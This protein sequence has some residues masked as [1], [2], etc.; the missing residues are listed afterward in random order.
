MPCPD[1]AY[2]VLMVTLAPDARID[3]HTHSWCS[4]GTE[5]PGVVVAQAAK[6]GLDVIGL[7]DHD[8]V[9]GWAQ[10]DAAGQEQGV[11]VVPGIE[12]SCNWRGISVHLLAYLPDPQDEALLAELSASRVSRDTRLQRMVELLAAD[13]FPITYD[14]VL[15]MAAAEASLGRPH[16][17]DVLVRHG[18]FPSRDE[19]FADVLSSHSRYYV[20]HHAPDPVHATEMIVAAGGVPVIAHPFASKRGE[21]VSDDLVADMAD[22]GMVGVEVDHRDHG[23][24]ERAHA[25]ALADRLRLVQ[26]GSSDYHGAGKPNRL[27][28]NTT[29]IASLEAILERATGTGLLGAQ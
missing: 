28:E 29:P 14:E 17:A 3:L 5:A 10:A 15:E 27:G 11:L 7:T 22:A 26:T 23:P 18:V 20:A 6:A 9:S 4:D 8:V 12:V 21:V 25:A 24:S 1:T 19:A 13:G 16:I 2:R